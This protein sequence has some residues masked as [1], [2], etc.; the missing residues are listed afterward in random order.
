MRKICGT[1]SR[2]M[3]KN[4]WKQSGCTT[5]H[6]GVKAH[7]GL[8]SW[9]SKDEVKAFVEGKPLLMNISIMM[10]LLHTEAYATIQ[11]GFNR[12]CALAIENMNLATK[13]QFELMVCKR[14]Y[15]YMDVIMHISWLLIYPTVMYTIWIHYRVGDQVFLQYQRLQ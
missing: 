11:H 4:L 15:F 8:P 9:E 1:S 10:C 12:V 13:P 6:M 14:V 2:K 3:S 7:V 5:R